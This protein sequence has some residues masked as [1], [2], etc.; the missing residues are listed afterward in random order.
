[1]TAMH[2]KILSRL[3]QATALALT[4]MALLSGASV[5]ADVTIQRVTN[6][7]YYPTSPQRFFE[8]GRRKLEREIQQL[9]DRQASQSGD[10]LNVNPDLPKRLR[11]D[12]IRQEIRQENE[13]PPVNPNALPSH[14]DR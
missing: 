11:D 1:M 5:A 2:H 8:E 7:L 13:S 12:L 9:S 10:V 3:T 14:S 6:S 4:T